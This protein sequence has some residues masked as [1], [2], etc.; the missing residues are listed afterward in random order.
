MTRSWSEDQVLELLV[1][2]ILDHNSSPILVPS[3]AV[4]T[5][6]GVYFIQDE[7]S[8]HIRIGYSRSISGR[9]RQHRHANSN[10]IRLVGALA[11]ASLKTE[12]FLHERFRRHVLHHSWYQAT[13]EIMRFLAVLRL[14]REAFVVRSYMEPPCRICRVC[15]LLPLLRE[16]CW[17]GD[18][19][20]WREVRW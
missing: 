15:D 8:G 6:S 16:P 12:S 2:T 13:D 18:P 11:G 20:Q 17:C 19:G 4:P 7:K 10:P 14:D 5:N 3:I 9:V 1:E